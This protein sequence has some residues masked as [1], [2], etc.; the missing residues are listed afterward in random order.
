M[1]VF[2]RQLGRN[3]DVDRRAAREIG[4]GRKPLSEFFQPVFPSR[5]LG[6]C[7]LRGNTGRIQIASASDGLHP[8]Q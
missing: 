3:D 6:A 5:V 7:D 1:R 8:A 4:R 2:I